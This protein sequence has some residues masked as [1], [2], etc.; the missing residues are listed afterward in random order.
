[1]FG[2]LRII[3]A[4]IVV[5]FHAGYSPCGIRMGVSAVIVFFILSGL[6]M[7]GLYA[8]GFATIMN[9]PHF[10]LERVTRIMPQLDWPRVFLD[11]NF[12]V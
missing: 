6:A 11:T 1:M 5:I 12:A 3:L 7:S 9:A 4:S 10:Y 2:Y 8:N